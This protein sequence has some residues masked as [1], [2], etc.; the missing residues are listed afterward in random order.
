MQDDGTFMAPF[1]H[2]QYSSWIR[3]LAGRLGLDFVVSGLRFMNKQLDVTLEGVMG[4]TM[5]STGF[6]TFLDLFSTTCAAGAAL[7][8]KASVLNVAIAPEPR[9]IRWENARVS[10][11]T[12]KRREIVTNILLSFGIFFWV[13]VN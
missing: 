6:V 7:S 11:R 5:S 1:S 10:E 2:Q 9:E 8:A 13:S 4:S 12:K 3:R